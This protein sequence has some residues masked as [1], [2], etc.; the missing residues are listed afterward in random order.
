MQPFASARIVL[1]DREIRF[2]T[3]M[4][5]IIPIVILQNPREQARI[6]KDLTLMEV[7]AVKLSELDAAMH[8]FPREASTTDPRGKTTCGPANAPKTVGLPL[9]SNA[10]V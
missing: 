6:V 8:P 4:Q 3:H 1:R 9:C 10:S 5:S 7:V 2:P